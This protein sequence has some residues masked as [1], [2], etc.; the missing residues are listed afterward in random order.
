MSRPLPN[1]FFDRLSALS[2]QEIAARGGL[3]FAGPN[4]AWCPCPEQRRPALGFRR[5]GRGFRCHRC[6]LSGNACQ[7]AALLVTG[8]VRP[9]ARGWKSVSEALSELTCE[10]F[11]SGEPGRRRRPSAPR[12][13]PAHHSLQSFWAALQPL[14]TEPGVEAWVAGR[15]GLTPRPHLDLA[16][17]E[18]NDLARVIPRG[19]GCPAWARIRGRTWTEAGYRLVLPMVDDRGRFAGLR[20]R[21]LEGLGDGLPKAVAPAGSTVDS[22]VLAEPLARR[23]LAGARLG[24]GTPAAQEVH[25][26]GLLV[27]EGEPSFLTAATRWSDACE[28]GMAVLGVVAGSW[29]KGIARRVPDGTRVLIATDDDEA[30][31]RYALLIA[32]SLEARC[33]V[34]R[35]LPMTEAADD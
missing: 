9:G 35:W 19:F 11:R 33:T 32:E 4:K 23:M 6:G 2:C 1:D 29:T 7:L 20:A 12:P 8:S 24:D 14:S 27:V 3:K 28:D 15:H 13:G 31:N 18:L 10:D 30:G 5:D 26:V 34:E 21:R 16:L 25:R 22:Q 17:A